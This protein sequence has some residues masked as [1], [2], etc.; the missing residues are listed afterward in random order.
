M[1]E[2]GKIPYR[3][4]IGIIITTI[5]PTAILYLPTITYKE[6]RQDGW[7]SVFII[8]L[9]SL[10]VVYAI[11]GLGTMYK[12][13]TIIEYSSDIIGKVPSK[14]L[15]FL[16]CVHFIYINAFIIRE[17][18]ELLSGAFMV[19]TPMLFFIIGI[20]LPSIYGVYKGLE[21]I[22]RVNQ[23]IFPIF[24]LS[25]LAIILYSI[26]DMDFT[27]VL[28]IMENGIKP[29]LLGGYRNFLW[30]TEVFVLAMFIP[31][32]NR[33]DKVRK[34]S[35]IAIIII[36]L[37]GMLINATIVATFGVNT[38]YL[39]YPYLS[40]ARY[41]SVG[42]IERLDS[43]IMFMWIGGVFIKIAVFHYCATLAIGQWLEI[44][45]FKFL[46]IPIGILLV[47]LSYVLWDNLTMV[48]YQIT[49]VAIVPFV[50]MQGVIPVLLFILT[51]IK[52]ILFEKT[53]KP[54]NI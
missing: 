24:M 51:K 10:V 19:E 46:S 29:I 47:I 6:A 5:A 21:V 34:L 35:I 7:I 22:I 4:V 23:M 38:E 12:D 16:Y 30:F 40:L 37:L 9:V 54:K 39:T 44:K 48:K 18:A 13:K 28:P 33:P 17:F 31:Y 20:I 49:Y 11:T 52:K 50:I 45:K 27:D 43:I 14:V 8:T 15:G 3:C 53:K 26:K 1:L 2:D 25:I 41:V 32:I 42:F 36:G